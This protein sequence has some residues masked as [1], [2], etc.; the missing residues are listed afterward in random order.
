MAISKDTRTGVGIC[1]GSIII[2]AIIGA[3]IVNWASISKNVPGI[4][5]GTIFFILLVGILYEGWKAVKPDVRNIQDEATSWK[6]KG[7]SQFR[8]GNFELAISFY[9]KGLELDPTNL[10]ILYNKALALNKLGKTEEAMECYETIR[11]IK[12]NSASEDIDKSP[13][14]EGQKSIIHKPVMLAVILVIIILTSAWAIFQ[15]TGSPTM[16]PAHIITPVI[17]T[18]T[19]VETMFHANAEHTGVFD[20]GGTVPANTELWR[21]KT[22]DWVDSSP[23]V[24]NGVVYVGSDGNNLYAIDALTGKEKWQFETGDWVSSSPAVSNGV[25]YVGSLDNNLYAIGAV[26]GKEMWRFNTRGS[27]HSSPAVSSGIVYVGSKDNNLYAIDAVTGNEKWRFKTG[28]IVDSSPAVSS[29]I[30]YVGSDD[31]NLY[32]IYEWSGKEKWRFKTGGIVDSS[33]AVSSG[34]V[35]VGSLDSNLYAIDAVTGKEKWKLKTGG[36]VSSS[37]AVSNGVVYFGSE[38]N[39][40][41]AIGGVSSTTT[42]PGIATTTLAAGYT[43]NAMP[44]VATPVVPQTTAPVQTVPQVGMGTPGPTQMLPVDYMLDFSV[45]GYGDIVSPHMEVTLM[46]GNGMYFDSRI[47]VTFTKPDGSSQQYFMR[48]P[49][50][51]GQRVTFQ[52]STDRNRVEIWVTAPNV[53]KVKTYDQI[54]PFKSINSY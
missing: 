6:D 11:N 52:C 20:N 23:A 31:S 48:P 10:D 22:G 19:A 17:P 25:V 13:K 51:V 37:P 45:Y 14:K 27:V 4:L 49:F 26:A 50:H 3:I 32:A 53:G 42:S 35:Y 43:Q 12:E 21:F 5:W 18:A 40:L 7:T 16:F 46:G 24:S 30:V 39:N 38:D 8:Q 1:C 44:Q 2:L 36:T 28:G 47:D 29:G 9:N 41:Y 34:I 33:P 54:L 15:F